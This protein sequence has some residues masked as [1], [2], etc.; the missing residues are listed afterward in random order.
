MTPEKGLVEGSI[1]RSVHRAHYKQLCIV[2][3]VKTNKVVVEALGKSG[4][5]LPARNRRQA[6]MELQAGELGPDLGDAGRLQVGI[7]AA[8]PV[9][10]GAHGSSVAGPFGCF[11]APAH[12]TDSRIR[13]GAQFT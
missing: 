12:R 4:V 1:W 8:E 7:A 11:H 3:Q 13:D 5:N 10:M 9:C 6:G 2:R